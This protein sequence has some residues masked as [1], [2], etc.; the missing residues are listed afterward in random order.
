MIQVVWTVYRRP[1][2]FKQA[3][4]S[5][6]AAR[7]EDRVQH[8]FMVEPSDK[9]DQQ[10]EL[11]RES[12]L[13]NKIRHLNPRRYGVLE[14]PWYGFNL[15]FDRAKNDSS[16]SP[17]V[18]IA[19]EDVLVS[20]DIVEYI[21]FAS[22]FDGDPHCL[23]VCANTHRPDLQDPAQLCKSASFDPLGWGTWADRWDGLFR[24]TWDHDYSTGDNGV[25]AGWDHNINHRLIPRDPNNYFLFPA[26]QS[27]TDH[28]GILEGA[29]MIPEY[30]KD[31][32][33]PT[34][35]LEVSPQNYY[36]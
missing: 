25:N 29:H 9:R 10:T 36:V 33:A 13:T 28:V 22:T 35:S 23:G 3:L 14:N 8:I 11:I 19:E 6:K 20:S 2:Y 4:A 12:G 1:S 34:F 26:G 18:F 30:F 5:W 16:L 7:G 27:R 17:F 15:A 24:D 21:E 31:S 32:Q